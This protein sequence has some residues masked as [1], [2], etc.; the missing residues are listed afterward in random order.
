MHFNSAIYVFFS[1][2]LT[3]FYGSGRIFFMKEKL[4]HKLSVGSPCLSTRQML[5]THAKSQQME[6]VDEHSGDKE[7]K[8]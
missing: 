7:R 8:T 6:K 2:C 1:L 5:V 3:D 4:I